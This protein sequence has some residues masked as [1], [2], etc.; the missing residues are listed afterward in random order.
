MLIVTKETLS[1]ISASHQR[2]NKTIVSNNY[3]FGPSSRGREGLLQDSPENRF[4][5]DTLDISVS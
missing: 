5:S 2:Q 1:P 3:I 4:L